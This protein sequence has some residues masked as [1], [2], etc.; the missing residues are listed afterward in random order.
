MENNIVVHKNSVE[1]LLS[2]VSDL[3][4]KVEVLTR[5]HF[6][7]VGIQLSCPSCGHTRKY[8]C[9]D[10]RATHCRCWNCEKS[11]SIEGNMVVE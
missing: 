3:E 10:Y 8:K 4:R 2:R 11:M 5:A 6:L 9:D 7:A 1:D